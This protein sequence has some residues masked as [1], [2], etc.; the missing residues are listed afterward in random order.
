M[1][2]FVPVAVEL[3]APE[4]ELPATAVATI[5][6]HV[7][8][9]VPGLFCFCIVNVSPD[10]VGTPRVMLLVFSAPKIATTTSPDCHEID[11]VDFVAPVAVNAEVVE[12]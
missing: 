11:A 7:L 8:L 9:A 10:T 2:E 12:L 4:L 3:M 6:A 1:P 5:E